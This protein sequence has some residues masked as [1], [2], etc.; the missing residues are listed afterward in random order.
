MFK[1]ILFPTDFSDVAMKALEFVEQLKD[2]GA[3]EV[4]L[5][6]VIEDKFFYLLDEYSTI[7]LDKFEKD[8]TDNVKKKLNSVAKA[9]ID[10]GFKVKVRIVRGSPVSEILKAE[11]DENVSL[12][13]LGSHG[14]S[15][16]K[17]M[18]LGSVS[19]SVIRKSKRPIFV[20]KR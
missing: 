18:F 10:R 17:E 15:N 8:M 11:Q 4:I 9:L 1:K 13:V 3:E 12:I 14:M 6:N 7:D 20:V 5:L 16:I 19:E 2:S